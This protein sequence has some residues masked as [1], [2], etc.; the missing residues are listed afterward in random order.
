MKKS[1]IKNLEIASIAEE[2]ESQFSTQRDQIPDDD[3]Y[4]NHGLE[5]SGKLHCARKSDSKHD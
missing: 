4:D 1:A 2:T 3:F 5:S